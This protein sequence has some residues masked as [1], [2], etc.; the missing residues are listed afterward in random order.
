MA[1]KEIK[2]GYFGKDLKHVRTLDDLSSIKPG[3]AVFVT[4]IF[5]PHIYNRNRIIRI[6]EAVYVCDEKGQ[7]VFT[8]RAIGS[9]IGRND[10]RRII[11]YNVNLPKDSKKFFIDY[12]D[13]NF[14]M[15]HHAPGDEKFED[16]ENLIKGAINK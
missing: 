14:S 3:E 2:S 1:E 11:Q 8:A 9:Y 13:R 6:R 10:E 5:P 4:H 15:I 12:R 16:L 7:K